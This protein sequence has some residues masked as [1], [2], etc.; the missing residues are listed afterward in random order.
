MVLWFL[1][2]S[3][4]LGRYS[5][6]NST[7]DDV[8]SAQGPEIKEKVVLNGDALCLYLDDCLLPSESAPGTCIPDDMA[9]AASTNVE[10]EILPDVDALLSWIFAGLSSGEHLQSWLRMKEEKVNHGVEILQTLEKEFYHL[11]SLCERKCEHLSYEE[12]LQALEDLCLEE[13]KKREMD[14]LDCSC[15]EYALRKRRDDIAENENNA[16]FVS[17]RIEVD[18]I[19]NVLKEAEDLNGSQLGYENTHSSLNSQLCDLE[20]GE[21]NDSKTKDIVHQMNTC[22]QV[23]IQRQKHQLSVEVSVFGLE[24]LLLF[25]TMILATLTWLFGHAAQQN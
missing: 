9:T 3:C 11:Q 17:S 2:H 25:V 14:T 18:V 5:E 22:I 12:A 7:K 21:D 6:K 8:N 20:F 1:S 23:V 24:A 13:S 16:L 4:G 10:N 15:Y 19:A